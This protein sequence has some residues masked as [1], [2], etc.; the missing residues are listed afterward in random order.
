VSKEIIKNLT[1]SELVCY[2]CHN[3]IESL[4]ELSGIYKGKEQAPFY[5]VMEKLVEAVNYEV[6]SIKAGHEKLQRFRHI[7][8]DPFNRT[9][10]FTV[11]DL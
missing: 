8:C 2:V 4:A 11:E 3:Q 6:V 7:D 1:A 10:T 9:H 5:K